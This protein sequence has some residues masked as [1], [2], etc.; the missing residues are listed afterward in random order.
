V[1]LG[2]SGGEPVITANVGCGGG[3]SGGLCREWLPSVAPAAVVNGP[4][5]PGGPIRSCEGLAP[6][7]TLPS[8]VIGAKPAAVCRWIFTLLGAGPGDTLDDL[9]PGSGVVGRAWAAFTRHP[10]QAALWA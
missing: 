2:E 7:D 1:G 8:R 4:A 9:F 5:V 3:L 10:E 6:L